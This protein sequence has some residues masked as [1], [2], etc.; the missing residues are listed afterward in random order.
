[1]RFLSKYDAIEH[2]IEFKMLNKK[3]SG[4][5]NNLVVQKIKISVL[6]FKPFKLSS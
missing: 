5:L 1:M 2:W 6:K 4:K 3:F